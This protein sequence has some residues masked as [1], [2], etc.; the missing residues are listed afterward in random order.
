MSQILLSLC[1]VIGVLAANAQ[2][3]TTRHKLYSS[4]DSERRAERSN[5]IRATSQLVLIPVTVYDSLGA[6]SRGL[7]KERFRIF[8]DGVEQSI[9]IVTQDDAPVSYGMVMD[10]SK[11]MLA[12]L[13][14]ARQA[15]SGFLETSIPGDEYQLVQF[16]DFPEVICN[17][18]ENQ[19][20][21]QNALNSVAARGWTAMFDGLRMSAQQMRNAKNVRKAL[22]IIS[23]GEDN[24]SRYNETEL[25]SY[26]Q[27][28]GV[29]VFSIGVST[30]FGSGFENRSLRRISKETGGW[31]YSGRLETLGET[32][33]AIGEAIRNQ[34]IVAYRPSSVGTEGKFRKIRVQVTT[35]QN[36]KLSATWRGGYYSQ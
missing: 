25:K 1:L 28:A 8:E 5:V 21:L 12:K 31:F 27:E 11:S 24:F 10:A 19:G 16:N 20:V 22:I 13:P 36:D 6:P 29:V 2:T 17:L 32:V 9:Q 18:T 23:D 15:F 34:Y 35:E 4:P 26:L 7:P 14:L 30:A 3:R 33:R